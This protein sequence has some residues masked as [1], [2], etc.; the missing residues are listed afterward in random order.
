MLLCVCVCLCVYIYMYMCI[1]LHIC[2]YL[3]IYLYWYVFVCMCMHNLYNVIGVPMN[4]GLSICWCINDLGALRWGRVVPLFL[5][6]ITSS[7]LWGIETLWDF[8]L[9]HYSPPLEYVILVEVVKAAPWS[10]CLWSHTS[11][12]PSKNKNP[13][14]ERVWL[15]TLVYDFSL[16]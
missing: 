14:G 16:L 12:L 3:P 9:P 13:F 7:S 2:I 6:L 5:A 1:Y 8:P 15:V 4:S 10:L 11:S